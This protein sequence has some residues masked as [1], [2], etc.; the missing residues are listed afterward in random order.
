MIYLRKKGGKAHIW[1]DEKD[2]TECKMWSTGGIVNKEKFSRSLSEDE[3]SI[4]LMCKQNK[5]SE[6]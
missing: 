3:E 4:C 6:K 1:N 5:M 2:D